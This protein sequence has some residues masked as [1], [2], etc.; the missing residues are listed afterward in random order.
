[1]A[2]SERE[3]LELERR[4]WRAMQEQDVETM[5]SLTDFPVVVTGPQGIGSLERQSFA[6]MMQNPSYEIEKF[7]IADDAKVRLVSDDLAI[8]AYKV[9]EDMKVDGKPVSIDAADSSTW[10]KR[11]GQWKCAL[12]TEA[13]AG[14]P[15]G[16]DRRS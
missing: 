1:M 7:E 5:M 6:A 13:I 15:Y 10:V 2:T 9:H 8:V 3:L 4:F 16:R 11:D 12:H 14:D